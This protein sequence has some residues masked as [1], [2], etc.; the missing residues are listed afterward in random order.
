MDVCAGEKLKVAAGQNTQ[1]SLRNA[2]DWGAFEGL[3]GHGNQFAD[4]SRFMG[5]RGQREGNQLSTFP[6]PTSRLLTFFSAS[7]HA[8]KGGDEAGCEEPWIQGYG[9]VKRL[10]EGLKMLYHEDVGL[11]GD[12]V[13]S[14]ALLQ[15]D[16]VKT[17]QGETV[18][19]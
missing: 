6:S 1:R 19:I 9:V 15:I 4:K 3:H 16:D 11:D 18:L 7:A 5:A 2:R 12:A 17:V 10:V 14:Y 8:A 13:S